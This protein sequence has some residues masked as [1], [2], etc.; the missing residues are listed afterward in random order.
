[1]TRVT[2]VMLVF[3]LSLSS[4]PAL[5]QQ[6]TGSIA[7][8]VVDASEA[9]ISAVTVTA[10]NADTGLMRETVTNVSGLYRLKAL[11]VGRYNVAAEQVGFAR[12]E[13][14]VIVNISRT[15]D[16]D[17]ILGVAPVAETIIVT[18]KAPLISTTSSAVGEIVDIERI[19]SLPLNGRQF[20]NLAAT[21]PGVGLG[22]H[23]DVTKSTQYAPQISGGNGR[24]VNYVVDGGDNNDDTV[25]GLLQLFPL[26]AIQEFNVIT[27]RFDAEYGRN[28]GAVLNVVT[29]SGTNQLRGSWFTL[30]RHDDL[31]APTFSEGVNRMAKQAYRRYQFGGSVGGPVRRDQA[32]FFAAFER[33]QQDT[34]QV[35]NTLG[36]FPAEDGAYDVRF[37][38]NLFTAKLTATPRPDHYLAFR[39][40]RDTNSQPT[41]AGLRA[42]R[43]SWATSRNTYDSVNGN[44]NWVIGG[45]RLNEL[46]VQY[47]RFV[48]DIPATSTCGSPTTSPQ[49]RARPCRRARNR[50]NGSCATTSHGRSQA[51]AVWD[52]I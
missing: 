34:M 28:G 38:E 7:G 37:R 10:S 3:A 14:H 5:A 17:I 16:F 47:G 26:E 32:H 23:S 2:R 45:S 36:L 24:N 11:P 40:A 48:N 20:A 51:W 25:G 49:G 21:V 19:E 12:F 35:V 15:T 22:F 4:W 31:N 18:A 42:A 52:T 43:S 29:K 44:H 1:M 9:G 8:R 50:R 27:Q 39:Y 6:T 33:T 41:G 13:R 46:V 30:L